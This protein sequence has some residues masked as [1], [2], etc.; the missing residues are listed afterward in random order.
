MRI[1]LALLMTLAALLASCGDESQTTAS[2]ALGNRKRRSR[3]TI[4]P[5]PR[6]TWSRRSWRQG[7][8]GQ[9]F[10]ARGHTG[11][12]TNGKKEYEMFVARLPTALDAAILLPDWDKSLAGFKADPSFGGYFGQDAA[13]LSRIRQ[14]R[15]DRRNRTGCRKKRWMRQPR[16]SGRTAH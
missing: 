16:Y 9:A 1:P 2:T 11:P 6:Q 12:I 4:A 14:R 3:P 5:L 7:N 10:H 8:T 15:M 13:V